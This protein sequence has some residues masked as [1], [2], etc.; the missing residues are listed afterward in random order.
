MSLYCPA[1]V[2]LLIVTGKHKAEVYDVNIDNFS[3]KIIKELQKEYTE[4]NLLIA[5]AKASSWIS[6]KYRQKDKNV[7]DRILRVSRLQIFLKDTPKKK[8]A[9]PNPPLSSYY[10]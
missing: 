4:E 6:D 5:I 9:K 3:Q 7:K 8:V 10:N 2:P 1:V